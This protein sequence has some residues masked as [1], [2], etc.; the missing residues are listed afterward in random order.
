M[1]LV[2]DRK[3]CYLIAQGSFKRSS[4]R[5]MHFGSLSFAGAF[6]NFV[7][8]GSFALGFALFFTAS[9]F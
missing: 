5:P 1:R 8:E 6:C 7:S 2:T 9:R 3:V 4:M